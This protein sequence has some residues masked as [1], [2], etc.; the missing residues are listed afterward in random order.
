MLLV[1]V[2]LYGGLID[3]EGVTPRK[4]PAAFVGLLRAVVGLLLVIG[5]GF[6]RQTGQGLPQV[7]QLAP[8]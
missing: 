6:Q 1:R 5:L 3:C 2:A 4:P 7:R 8:F